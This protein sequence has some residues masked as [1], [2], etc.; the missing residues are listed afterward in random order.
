MNEFRELLP[1]LKQWSTY[2]DIG[3]IAFIIYKLMMLI[4]E[5][6]AEQLI[7]GIIILIVITK[8]SDIMQLHTM[9]WLLKNAMTVGAIAIL[10]IFQP[11]LRRALEHI[12]RGKLF[13]KNEL[14][15][16][17]IDN[18][19]REITTTVNELSK[20]KIGAIIVLEQDTGLNEFIE[21]GVRIDSEISAGLFLTIFAPNTPLHDG[22]AI[23]R[24]NRILAAGCFLPLTDNQNLSKQ[25]GTRHRA[26]RGITEISESLVIVVSEETGVISV[27]RDGKLSRYLD[28]KSLK[29]I[30]K[31]EYTY[32]EQLVLP[33]WGGKSE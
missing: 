11:E 8:L 18:M 20:N 29:E 31:N 14:Q 25:L 24:K 33:K 16:Q 19:L 27:A 6:R 28:P 17:E 26:A 22:A 3:I 23:V 13:A 30:L 15:K 4:K 9:Y 5:T 21:T 2:L 32:K 1:F 10:I 12:G 7:K